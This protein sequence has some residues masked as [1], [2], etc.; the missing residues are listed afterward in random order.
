MV[1]KI[2]QVHVGIPLKLSYVED[3]LSLDQF[4]NDV[5][6]QWNYLHIQI[7]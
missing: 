7:G 1:T 3:F 5:L 6:L 2:H 4:L